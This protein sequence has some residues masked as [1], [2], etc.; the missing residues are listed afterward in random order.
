MLL[1]V[2]LHLPSMKHHKPELILGIEFP[3]HLQLL[4]SGFDVL[5]AFL[6]H[7]FGWIREWLLYLSEG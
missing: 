6:E 4:G 2:F 1:L 3:N 5:Q 7:D